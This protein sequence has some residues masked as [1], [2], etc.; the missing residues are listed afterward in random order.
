MNELYTEKT[1]KLSLCSLMKSINVF[2]QDTVSYN[3]DDN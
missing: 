1:P 3:R 2:S